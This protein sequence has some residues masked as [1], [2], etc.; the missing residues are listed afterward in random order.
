MSKDQTEKNNKRSIINYIIHW[1]FQTKFIFINILCLIVLA[2]ALGTFYYK[3]TYTSIIDILS[4]TEKET[5]K[6]I[7]AYSAGSLY[8]LFAF[9]LIYVVIVSVVYSHRI[10]GPI[11]RIK[12]NLNAMLNGDLSVDFSTRKNDEFTA[13]STELQA[14]TNSFSSLIKK[15][16]NNTIKLKGIQTNDERNKCINEIDQ[17]ISQYKT[18]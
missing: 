12:K 18:F 1:K 16:R 11:Q 7:L 10:A 9:I 6:E 5:I 17:S 13:L 8:I 15:I 14:F 2:A 4:G 3:A